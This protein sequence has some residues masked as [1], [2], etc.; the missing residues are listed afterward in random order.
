MTIDGWPE[1]VPKTPADAKNIICII[2]DNNTKPVN[3]CLYEGIR[4]IPV[5]SRTTLVTLIELESHQKIGQTEFLH[6]PECPRSLETP[7]GP[8]E[9]RELRGGK[10]TDEEVI[11]WA[12]K[13]WSP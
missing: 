12:K 11:D 2:P 10:A 6:I 8:A 4:S 9:H 7:Q 13:R 3:S 5:Y 1:A